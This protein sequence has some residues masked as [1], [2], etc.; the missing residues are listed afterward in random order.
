MLALHVLG[1]HKS[2][3]NSFIEFSLNILSNLII[4]LGGG[5][6]NCGDFQICLWTAWHVLHV[7]QSITRSKQHAYNGSVCVWVKFSLEQWRMLC[8]KMREC[9]FSINN[10][11][12]LLLWS[13]LLG[14]GINL[15]KADQTKWGIK[16]WI[17]QL[18]SAFMIGIILEM[19]K[20]NVQL[21]VAT[22]SKAKH[23]HHIHVVNKTFLYDQI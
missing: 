10:I 16:H 20:T 8:V 9:A 5:K 23:S 11:L 22:G 21:Q 1:S 6:S 19:E 17:W 18:F 15:C 12:I 13:I 2:T 3:L 7:A 4:I 14:N